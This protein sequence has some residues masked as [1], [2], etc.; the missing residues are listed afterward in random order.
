MASSK[1]TIIDECFRKD[2][3]YGINNSR[4]WETATKIALTAS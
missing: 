3:N 4:K 1:R 2:E